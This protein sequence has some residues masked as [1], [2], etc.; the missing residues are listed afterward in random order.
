MTPDELRKIRRLLDLTASR[1]GM[2]SGEAHQLRRDCAR[3]LAEVQRL[4]G[5]VW[6]S[7]GRALHNDLTSE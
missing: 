3:L 2:T 1:G 5:A 4:R 6:L 7:G